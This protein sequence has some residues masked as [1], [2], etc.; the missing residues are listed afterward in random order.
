[1]R[2]LIN[3][4]IT[5]ARLVVAVV[6]VVAMDI[7]II[8]VTVTIIVIIIIAMTIV[9]IVDAIVMIAFHEELDY[10]CSRQA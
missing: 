8:A 7:I 1:M 9:F 4:H 5:L 6:V 3:T 2:R 10:E